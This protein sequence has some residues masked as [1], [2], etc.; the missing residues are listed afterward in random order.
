MIVVS[1]HIEELRSHLIGFYN[2]SEY[3]LKEKPNTPVGILADNYIKDQLAMEEGMRQYVESLNKI[4]AYNKRI[5]RAIKSV[6]GKTFFNHLIAFI[7]DAEAS[8]YSQFEIVAKPVGKMQ[9]VSEYGREIKKEWVVQQAVGD[10]GD[11]WSGSICVQIKP[12]K[13][14]K[15]DFSM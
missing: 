6:K 10:S 3:T 12:N 1:E 9:E 8:E 4:N 2:M 13:Y 14:L 7:K 15:F 11:S 5:L